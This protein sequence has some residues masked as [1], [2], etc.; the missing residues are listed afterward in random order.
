M[1]K[2][3][4]KNKYFVVKE[5]AVPEVLLNVVAAKK[6]L[7][8]KRAVTVQEAADAVGISRSS[9]YKYKDD[10]FPFHEEA[11][12]KTITFI[13]QMDDEPGILS[14]VLKTIAEYKANLL[15][16]HQTIPVN[17]VASL[18]LSV[19]I[20]PTTGD[21]AKMIEQIEQLSGVRYLKILSRE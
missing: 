18:T 1:P 14:V 12:G 3:T 2:T 17:G 16:I 21:S 4:D 7:E 13:I 15:T 19:D 6:L 10:I 20:L 11:K 8:S 5:R 9:F